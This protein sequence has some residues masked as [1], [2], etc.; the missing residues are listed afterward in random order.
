[1]GSVQNYFS[2]FPLIINNNE[3]KNSNCNNNA[4]RKGMRVQLFPKTGALKDLIHISKKKETKIEKR[5]RVRKEK[6][7][8]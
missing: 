1:M 3:I 7:R 8:E 5:D 4:S 2:I 6:E